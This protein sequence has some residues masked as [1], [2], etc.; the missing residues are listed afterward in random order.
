MQKK[1]AKS[2]IKFRHWLMAN[3][4]M[5]CAYEMKD[6]RG[7]SSFPMSEWKEAQEIFA[8]AIRYGKKGVLIRTEGVKGLPD[9][10]Y[11]HNA[12]SY[13]VIKYPKGFTIISG[14]ALALEKKRADTNLLTYGRAKDIA[15]KVIE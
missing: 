15:I 4:Q 10:V 7:K 9:Y 12:P 8:E 6:T 13:V 11:L 1:E 14:D 3:P 5:T 2:S